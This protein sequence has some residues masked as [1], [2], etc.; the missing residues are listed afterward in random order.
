MVN[1]FGDAPRA[2]SKA[3]KRNGMRMH[4]NSNLDGAW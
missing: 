1:G 2:V 4:S 3:F